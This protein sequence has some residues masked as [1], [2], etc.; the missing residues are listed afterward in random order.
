MQQVQNLAPEF[1]WEEL[2]LV[3]VGD[4]EIRELNHQYFQKNT[5]TD[6]I[7]FAYPA[8]AG[9]QADT[10]EVIVN[11]AQAWH[12][13]N[14]RKGPNHEL[15]RYIAHGCHHLMGAEDDTAEKK[16]AML[17]LEGAWLREAGPS[18]LFVAS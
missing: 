17:E 1:N 5:I 8:E 10:G 18:E 6:V 15:A 3:L 2:S 13:G 14:E 4:A 11:I 16:A 12:E 9:I 7:S